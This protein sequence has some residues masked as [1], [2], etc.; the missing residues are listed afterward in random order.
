MSAVAVSNMVQ[1]IRPTDGRLAVL[2]PADWQNQ[3]MSGSGVGEPGVATRWY[4]RPAILSGESI[5]D[6]ELQTHRV[7]SE[8]THW[9]EESRLP[10]LELGVERE[11][12][13]RLPPLQVVEVTMDVH[14]ARPTA[15]DATEDGEDGIAVLE[16]AAEVGEETAFVQAASGIDWLQSPAADFAR[17]VHLALTAGAHL[18]ARKLANYGYR[19][20]PH[21]AELAKMAHILAPPRVVRANLSPDPSVRVNLEWMRIHAAEYRGR[22]V[23]LKDG[24]LLTTAPT[25]CELKDQLPTT[26]GLFLTRVI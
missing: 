26:D 13:V 16:I 8:F 9:V 20:Y 24:V 21:H 10:P 14:S 23:A 15:L 25:A 22:W 4:Y 2:L 6:F 12:I 7:I 3:F 11:I 18:L 5:V 19:L 1:Q 17:A